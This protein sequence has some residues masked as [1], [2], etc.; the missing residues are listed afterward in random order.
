MGKMVSRY[1]TW[2]EAMKDRWYLHLLNGMINL[3]LSVFTAVPLLAYLCRQIPFTF[4]ANDDAVVMQI[5]DGSYTGSP[6]AHAVFIRYPI[7]AIIAKLYKINPKFSIFVTDFHDVVWYVGV[8]V[9]LTGIALVAVLFR[10]LDYFACNRIL[11]CLLFDLGFLAVWLTAFS[12]LTFSTA[13]AFMG[14]MALLFLGFS[15]KETAWR[16][17]NVL[18]LAIFLVAAYDF[19]KQCLLMVLPLVLVEAVLKYHI[20]FF[21][22]IKPWVLLILCAV[23][24]GGMI[25]FDNHMYSSQNWKHY[26]AYNH[27]RAY[28]QDYKGF[29]EYDQAQDFYKSI[30]VTPGDRELMAHYTYGFSDNFDPD[31]VEQTSDYVKETQADAPLKARLRASQS[32]ARTYLKESNQ[33][34]EGLKYFSFYLSFLTIPLLAVTAVFCFKGNVAAI[35]CSAIELILYHAL[36]WLEFLYLAMNER[37]PQRVEEAIRLLMLSGALVIVGHLLACWKKVKVGRV[38][39]FQLSIVLQMIIFLFAMPYAR[40]YAKKRI[41]YV[42]GVQNYNRD[43]DSEKE[44]VLKY[45]G[46][47]PKNIYILDTRSFTKTSR[48][49]DETRQGNWIMSGSWISYSP[50]YYQKLRKYETRTLGESFY[51][52]PNVYIVTKG[53]KNLAS[54]FGLEDKR[55][56]TSHISDELVTKTN[57]FFEIYKVTHVI[58]NEEWERQEDE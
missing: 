5:L 6:E 58:T 55:Q 49:G 23:L 56:V 14:C 29:P 2:K 34:D 8:I 13:A 22:S 35:I 20:H 42:K 54:L 33:T 40:S 18:L 16:P 46:S 57:A 12:C 38:H 1:I 17:W 41:S 26:L 25:G 51:T 10:M 21:K 39:A 4:E 50:L 53:P 32:L 3:V 36:I 9:I 11:I 28:L 24:V 45:C 48:P 27:A 52:R 7:S 43:Y 31:W 37:F 47:H 44:E 19:R 30:G 15:R